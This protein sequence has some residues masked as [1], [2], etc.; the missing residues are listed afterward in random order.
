MFRVRF[1]AASVGPAAPSARCLLT[2]V[3]TVQAPLGFWS[4]V[5][6]SRSDTAADR[7]T[8]IQVG[9]AMATRI[10]VCCF[11]CLAQLVSSGLAAE[12][13][14]GTTP[15]VPP[16]EKRF[17]QLLAKYPDLA[18]QAF[19]DEQPKREYVRQLSFDPATAAFYAKVVER[20]RLTNEE[21]ALIHKN[22]FVL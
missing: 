9:T 15:P 13:Q 7:S 2:C 4:E 21:Q 19:L 3:P 11:V 12:T 14:S 17:E 22:G 20:L 8:T 10:A 6:R 1:R 16:P 5:S 18:F